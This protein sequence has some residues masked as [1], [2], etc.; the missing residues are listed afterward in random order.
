MALIVWDGSE[1]GADDLTAAFR[2]EARKRSCLHREILT[3]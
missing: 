1:R 3:R 2:N